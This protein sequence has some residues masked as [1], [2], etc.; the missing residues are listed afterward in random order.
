M[1]DTAIDVATLLVLI[2]ILICLA[3]LV[4]PNIKSI[5]NSLRGNRRYKDWEK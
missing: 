1:M 5:V 4:K 2:M 3:A